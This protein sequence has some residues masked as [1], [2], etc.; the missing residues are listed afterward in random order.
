[1]EVTVNDQTKTFIQELE[2]MIL[3]ARKYGICKWTIQASMNNMSKSATHENELYETDK[4]GHQG[5]TDIRY[6]YL[7]GHGDDN[8]GRGERTGEDTRESN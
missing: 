5:H 7:T 2:V 6:F 8:N 1:M 4:F 3:L